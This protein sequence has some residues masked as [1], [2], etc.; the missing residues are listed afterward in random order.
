MSKYIRWKQSNILLFGLFALDFYTEGYREQAIDKAD[1][2]SV[3]L[4]L[5]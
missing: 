2:K 5:K 4:R 1:Q 3:W